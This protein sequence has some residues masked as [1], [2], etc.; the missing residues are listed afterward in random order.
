MI[1]FKIQTELSNTKYTFPHSARII[2]TV[3]FMS[4]LANN[5]F[6]F[7]KEISI[8]EI[9]VSEPIVNSFFSL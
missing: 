2:L 7:I 4:I 3:I 9:G 5:N 1:D 6:L 8:F